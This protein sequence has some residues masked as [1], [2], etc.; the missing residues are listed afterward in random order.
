MPEKES[1]SNSCIFLCKAHWTNLLSLGT[2]NNAVAR[3]SGAIL[4]S[5]IAKKKKKITKVHKTW[6]WA[7]CGKNPFLVTWEPKE[8]SVALLGSVRKVRVR[9]LKFFAAPHISLHEC[10]SPTGIDDKVINKY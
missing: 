2:P 7:Y 1:L 4:N 5:E 9:W 3:H 10:E 6:L 8:D